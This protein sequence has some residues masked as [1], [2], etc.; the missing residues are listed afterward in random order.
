MPV[1]YAPG[2]TKLGDRELRCGALALE[3]S[4]NGGARTEQTPPLD[5]V[6]VAALLGVRE[7]RVAHGEKCSA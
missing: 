4:A 7:E 1:M 6:C 3:S 2:G 5:V